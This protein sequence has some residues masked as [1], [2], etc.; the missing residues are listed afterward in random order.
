MCLLCFGFTQTYYFYFKIKLKSDFR[1]GYA[2]SIILTLTK[3]MQRL[4]K[5]F[6]TQANHINMYSSIQI[7]NNQLPRIGTK[8]KF[9][10]MGWF[11]KISHSLYI[12]YENKQKN[13]MIID[14]YI[15]L[16]IQ[17]FD[18]QYPRMRVKS[19]SF[20]LGWVGFSK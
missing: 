3:D 15:Y 7:F 9:S 17:I 18:G 14:T 1:F 8:N 10:I 20:N 4:R 12:T 5:I 2:N 6:Q 11:L 16:L 13:H 19:E